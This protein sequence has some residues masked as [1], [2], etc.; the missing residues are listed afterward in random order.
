MARIKIDLLPLWHQKEM[1][2]GN[3][4]SIREVADATGLSWETVNKIKRNKTTRFDTKVLTRLCE[5]FEV[6]DGDLIPFL[7][8]DYAENNKGE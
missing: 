7:R 3:D 6:P 1:E 8:I 2:T 5:Y 4:L